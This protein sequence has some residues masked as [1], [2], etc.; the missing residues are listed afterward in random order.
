[1]G[2]CDRVW[3]ALFACWLLR[4]ALQYYIS[5]HTITY[6]ARPGLALAWG[7]SVLAARG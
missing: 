7:G 1:M 4:I 5:Y 2:L 6:Q 3:I